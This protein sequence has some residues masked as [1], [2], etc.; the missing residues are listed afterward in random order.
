[1]KARNESRPTVRLQAMAL[2]L[3]CLSFSINLKCL[4][5]SSAVPAAS[6]LE[7]VHATYRFPIS[8]NQSTVRQG[9]YTPPSFGKIFQNSSWAIL[10]RTFLYK[11]CI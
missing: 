2:N 3:G 9:I 7:I 5:A 8:T 4:S 6:A 10:K 1:M 11:I